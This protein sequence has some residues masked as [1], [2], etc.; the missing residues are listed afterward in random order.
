MDVRVPEHEDARL[1]VPLGQLRELR[2]RGHAVEDVLD[3]VVEGAVRDRHSVARDRGAGELLEVRA[4]VVGED[5]HRPIR[6]PGLSPPETRDAFVV[7]A[8]KKEPV[9]GT[10]QR[11]AGKTVDLIRG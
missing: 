3:G 5:L 4:H 7:I 9:S 8:V 11:T 2:F 10:D 6:L 1:R